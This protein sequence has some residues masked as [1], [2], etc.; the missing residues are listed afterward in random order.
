VQNLV[1]NE[2]LVLKLVRA[3]ETDVSRQ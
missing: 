2:V 1:E 3:D